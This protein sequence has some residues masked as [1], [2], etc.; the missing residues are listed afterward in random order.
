MENYLLSRMHQ[1]RDIA[2]FRAIERMP[3]D[4]YSQNVSI[5]MMITHIIIPLIL[6]AYALFG[7]LTNSLDHILIQL[8]ALVVIPGIA[9]A[10]N[11]VL[12]RRAL[13]QHTEQP[14]SLIIG[15]SIALILVSISLTGGLYASATFGLLVLFVMAVILLDFKMMAFFYSIIITFFIG[16]FVVE[17]TGYLPSIVTFGLHFHLFILICTLTTLWLIIGYHKYALLKSGK[18]MA[19][20]QAQQARYK[21]Q[22]EL[23]QNL[24]HDLRTP[25]TVIRSTTYLIRKRQEKGIPIDEKLENLE[26]VTDNM[27]QM[28]EDLLALTMLDQSLSSNTE[29][30]AIAEL[31][32]K[33]MSSL[34]DYAN[35]NS[36][37]L[38]FS[39]HT[40]GDL[41]IIGSLTLLER[42][43]SNLIE[44]AIH[45]NNAGGTVKTTIKNDKE[46]IYIAVAD[47]GI[48]IA[49]EH[50][51]QIFERFFRVGDA[52]TINDRHGTGIGLSVVKR[53][54]QLHGG[55]ITVDSEL[56][57][58]TTF[59]IT[60]PVAKS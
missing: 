8:L 37:E 48:G 41:C 57:K 30:I 55:Q 35:T 46:N 47:T 21:V 17:N 16:L 15:T 5:I 25:I 31:I 38:F 59:T 40:K 22:Q 51:H 43:I 52:R 28:I 36:I 12:L 45:Y 20:L 58:G 50:H 4:Q 7:V 53:I 14:V 42:A 27:T 11:L 6:M 9:F 54:I 32:K 13:R 19:D 2:T 34:K 49:P 10:V 23:T 3:H 26:R 60:L 56:G 44:N 1:I 39:D 29:S 24:A 18:L 33:T